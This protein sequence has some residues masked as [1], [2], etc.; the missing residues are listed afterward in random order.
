MKTKN[1]QE[2]FFTHNLEQPEIDFLTGLPNR[3]SFEKSMDILLRPSK[4]KAAGYALLID[5][6]DFKA[7]NQG[8]GYSA[9][10]VLISSFAGYLQAAFSDKYQ[11]FRMH[12]DAFALL[13]AAMPVSR[14]VKD[15]EA[16]LDRFQS[17]WSIGNKMTFC[18]ASIAAVPFP[19]HGKSVEEIYQNLNN[20]L[21][22]VRKNSKNGFSIYSEHTARVTDMVSRRHA[23][24]DLLREA[25]NDNFSGFQLHYQPIM[26]PITERVLGAEALLRFTSKSGRTIP[27]LSF[28]PLAEQTGL[29]L[30]IGT[31]VLQ[32]A[33]CFCKTMIDA[34]HKNFFM[35][36]NLSICQ[37]EVPHFAQIVLDILQKAGVPCANIVLE[38]TESMAASNIELIQETC[39][40]LLD[41]GIHIALDDFGTGYSSLNMIR[42]LPVDG[43]KI[44]RCFIQDMRSD[45][46]T[47]SFVRLI[48]ELKDLLGFT[49]YAEGVEQ[50]E[51]LSTCRELGVD[52][53]QGYLF[54]KA[55]PEQELFQLM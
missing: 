52:L 6:D 38:I 54:Y 15:M 25:I 31:Y 14:L 26:C 45:K 28:I 18:S 8:F 40:I 7:I 20:T 36:I 12:G 22:E 11:I 5:I 1:K 50:T 24:E 48:T 13:G 35:N 30:P 29:I 37:L 42:T 39:Q 10:D 43:I 41:A 27:P 23:L 17:P 21:Y 34:G 55:M 4:I 19:T 51:Q 44:D 47:H 16:I 46:Y 33:V 49:V 53:I 3:Y 9:G 32:T 2:Q